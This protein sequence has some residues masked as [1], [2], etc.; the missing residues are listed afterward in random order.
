M[1]RSSDSCFADCSAIILPS[2]KTP[3]TDFRLRMTIGTYSG[4]TVRDS[5]PVILF[6]KGLQNKASATQQVFQLSS[7]S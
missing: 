4:G 6:S 3:V 2:R 7:L 1:R 5:H